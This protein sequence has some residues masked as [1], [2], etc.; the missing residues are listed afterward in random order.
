MIAKQDVYIRPKTMMD[1]AHN[2]Y[3]YMSAYKS[4]L[5]KKEVCD[6]SYSILKFFLSNVLVVFVSLI[7][8]TV[9][10]GSS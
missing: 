9:N 8:N 1:K 10:F 2:I 3:D 5:R 7:H 4:Y 6:C